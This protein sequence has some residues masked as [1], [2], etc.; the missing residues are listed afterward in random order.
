MLIRSFLSRKKSDFFK[1]LSLITFTALLEAAFILLLRILVKTYSQFHAVHEPFSAHRT[2][3]YLII[4]GLMLAVLTRTLCQMRLFKM[5]VIRVE[6]W[7]DDRRSALFEQLGRSSFPLYREGNVSLLNQAVSEDLELVKQGLLAWLFS[8]AAFIQM[9]LFLPLLLLFPWQL[10][11]LVLL[12]LIP[13]LLISRI[14]IAALNRFGQRWVGAS[15]S[16]KKLVRQFAQLIEFH[17][18]NGTFHPASKRLLREV[19]SR[20]KHQETWEFI[21]AIFPAVME[22]FFFLMIAGIMLIIMERQFRLS[23]QVWQLFPF[24][25]LLLLMYKPVREWSRTFPLFVLGIKA[26]EAFSSFFIRIK[27]YRP[28]PAVMSRSDQVLELSDVSFTYDDRDDERISHHSFK[29]GER[30]PR[31]DD[32]STAIFS[33]LNLHVDPDRISLVQGANGA[34][35]S[36]LLKLIARLEHPRSG[37]IFY[38]RK[39]ITGSG[40]SLAYLP[41]RCQIDPY[42]RERMTVFQK[43]FPDQW[44]EL[45]AILG[46]ERLLNKMEGHAPS[47]TLQRSSST[48]HNPDPEGLSGGEH[49]RIC[50]AQ[51]MLSPVHY[52]LLDEPTTW[53]P[54]QDRAGIMESLLEFWLK[55][56]KA[57][58][59]RG[60]LIAS[61]EPDLL[62]LSETLIE[63]TNPGE[64]VLQE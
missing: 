25:V 38:P 33:R 21:R 15:G 13:V 27:D 26:W 51:V 60:V 14:R 32:A 35:K 22:T 58:N 3:T 29:E 8:L 37:K 16:I 39:W 34:G 46:L 42:I 1:I 49:Q 59:R 55:G 52:L 61:H 6:E 43:K 17:S 11:L 47:V 54:A 62:R 19:K 28:R 5:M 56:Q 48:A 18:G 57:G 30:K 50:L 24:M 41:Q 10:G 4:S 44:M 12:L 20:E 45:D 23:L 9:L 53:L 2:S 64:L 40:L 63:F 31:E 7:A 36:T